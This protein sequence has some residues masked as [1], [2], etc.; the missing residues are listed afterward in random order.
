MG[1]VAIIGLLFGPLLCLLCA[2][3]FFV[4]WKNEHE[5]EALAQ[6]DRKVCFG[7]LI[8][9]AVALVLFGVLKLL[10]PIAV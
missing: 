1:Y 8:A 3:W 5:N 6:R 10:F 2:A 4:R 9:A 7:C